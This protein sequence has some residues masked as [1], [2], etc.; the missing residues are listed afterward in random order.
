[1]KFYQGKHI[2]EYFEGIR[3]DIYNEITAQ[4]DNY[5]L[6][7]NIEDYLAHLEQHFK[8]VI[9][10]IKFDNAFVE[11]VERNIPASHFPNHG[12]CFDE[13]NKSI[14]KEVMIYH[15][16]YSGY[17]NIFNYRPNPFTMLSGE[18]NEKTSE[19]CILIEVINFYDKPESIKRA[20]EDQLRTI[21]SNYATIRS[22]CATFNASLSTHIGSIIKKR[23]EQVLKKN[24]LAASLGVPLRKKDNVAETFAIPKPK[25]REKIIVKPSVSTQDF[26]PEPTL[27]DTNYHEI[28]KIINDV[29]K[30]FE[31]MPS[32]YKGKKEE[33]I[34]DHILMVLD[35]NF[36][37]GSAGGE[38]FNHTGKT[39]IS[40]RHD[41]SVV[42]VAECKYWKGEVG[43]LKTIDQLL[44]YLTWRN[45]K[46]ALIN[47]VQNAEFTEVLYKI[48]TA[49]EKH[50]NFLKALPDN[51]ENWFNY[52]F[53]LNG[54]RGRLLTMAVI[55]YHLPK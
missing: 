14:R 49:T 54:D 45:S 38:T 29:G 28:L 15:L 21:N 6:N 42:F 51:D 23:Q 12:F 13:D 5:I 4:T 47:F 50:P 34:R 11:V 3:R 40:L 39:D 10:E 1:M 48:K 16:P 7:V 2:E 33:D 25:L 22:N 44:A 35:P 37:Y 53:H 20:Y 18:F 26:K 24:T 30:N 32:T 43:Y 19:K 36:E 52:Q 17:T 55:S 27:D 8:I 31:R 46:V 41:S 9:P